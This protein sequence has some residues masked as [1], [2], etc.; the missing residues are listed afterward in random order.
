VVEVLPPSNVPEATSEAVAG[1][2]GNFDANQL[3]KTVQTARK[4]INTC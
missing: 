1:V 3:K 2:K 4:E